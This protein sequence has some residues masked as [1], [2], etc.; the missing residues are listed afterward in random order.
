M[1]SRV[2]PLHI[3]K[4]TRIQL[5]LLV[6]VFMLALS[7]LKSVEQSNT[8]Y[9]EGVEK[10]RTLQH[11]VFGP[12]TLETKNFYIYNFSR[13]EE[14]FSLRKD[15]K[16]HIASLTK[17]MTALTL[18]RTGETDIVIPQGAVIDFENN[19]LRAGDTLDVHTL[20]KIMLISSSNNIAQAFHLHFKD[21]QTTHFVERMN[22]NALKLG[23]TNTHFINSTGLDEGQDGNVSTAEDMTKLMYVV[24]KRIPTV[25]ESTAQSNFTFDAP[26]Y[27]ST[28]ITNTNTILDQI[29][30]ILFSK[31]G[32]TDLAGG[33]LSIM[34]TSPYNGDMIGITLLDSTR[35]G[36][37]S[38]ML[39]L[40]KKTEEYL[41]LQDEKN[42]V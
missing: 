41:Q 29:P 37:F 1:E 36:R 8:Q 42:A 7:Y 9:V 23:L 26:G 27:G 2:S 16:K 21:S 19:G 4:S 17:T 5:V 31:T 11:Q 14:V 34:Y 18:E 40:V 38:D 32:Y 25:A 22:S 3:Q 35:N 28:L 6:F 10:T 33:T 13:S 39:T 12:M 15:Q 20:E 30:N 24:L